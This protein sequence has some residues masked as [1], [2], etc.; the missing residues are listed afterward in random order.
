MRPSL[1]RQSAA[2]LVLAMLMLPGRASAVTAEERLY[3]RAIRSSAWIITKN[4]CGSGCVVDADNRLLLT[5]YHVAQE[6]A[7]VAVVFP[8]FAKGR[9]ID[10]RAYYWKNWQKL[11]VRGQVIHQDQKRDLALIQVSRLPATARALK[12]ATATPRPGDAVYRI[13]SPGAD[14]ECWRL[15]QGEVT[16]V[17]TYTMQYPSGQ[18]VSCRIVHSNVPPIAGHSGSAVINDRGELVAIHAAGGG[19]S[20]LSLSVAASVVRGFL[21]EGREAGPAKRSRREEQVDLALAA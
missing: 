18:V 15:V 2:L 8:Q 17:G 20:E 21:E 19:G 12:L 14:N 1:S 16:K 9:L 10:D 4:S 5:N 13:G 11:S 7:E 6:E 3:N